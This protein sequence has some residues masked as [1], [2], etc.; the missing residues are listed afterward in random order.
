MFWLGKNKHLFVTLRPSAGVIFSQ[1]VMLSLNNSFKAARHRWAPL[2]SLRQRMVLKLLVK[3]LQLQRLTNT[4]HRAPEVN[5]K[6]SSGS[7]RRDRLPKH[8]AFRPTCNQPQYTC[9]HR[10]F[11]PAFGRS[12]ATKQCSD[13]WD[14][15]IP[16]VWTHPSCHPCFSLYT[17]GPPTT[18]S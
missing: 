9:M 6:H 10:S 18:T 5:T 7:T 15:N 2:D 14:I 1:N 11:V 12:K 13:R 8:D 4:K 17:L 3:Q 16:T